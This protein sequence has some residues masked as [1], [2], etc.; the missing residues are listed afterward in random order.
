MA[1]VIAQAASFRVLKSAFDNRSIMLGKM[2]ASMTAWICCRLPAAIFE[3]VQ[4]ASFRMVSFGELSS[5]RIHGKALQLRISCVCV[6]LPV[7]MF[8][9]ARRAA[10]T[11]L[12]LLCL[13]TGNGSG[14]NF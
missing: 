1:F 4:Q 8:P 13:E 12:L 14:L 7:T 2:L 6:S 5:C 9:T 10:E 3:M 11:T